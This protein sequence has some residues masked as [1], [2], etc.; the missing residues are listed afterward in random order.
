MSPHLVNLIERMLEPLITLLIKY[1]VGYKIF[2]AVAKNV[3]VSVA[4][5]NYGLRSK[6]TNIS[7]ISL[8][9]DLTRKDAASIKNKIINEKGYFLEM[10]TTLTK[11]FNIWLN[12][13]IFLDKSNTPRPLKYKGESP[14]FCD[15]VSKS[16]LDAPPKAIYIELERLFII[17]K[18]SN[19]FIS[20]RNFK[21]ISQ[22]NEEIL[23][24]RLKDLLSNS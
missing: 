24:S 19:G 18:D 10:N 12:D 11:L 4:A 6:D 7:R 22:A 3:F 14:S 5:K 23:A 21:N 13:D 17:E 9:T 1:G 8:M 15:L 20:L 16:K 2:D